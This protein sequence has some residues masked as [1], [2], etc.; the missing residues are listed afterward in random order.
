ML[1]HAN[2]LTT[3]LRPLRAFGTTIEDCE[4]WR[5]SGCCSSVVDHWLAAQAIGVR[6]FHF[7][8]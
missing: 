7:P 2:A 3:E 6:P 5:L 4:D 8:S 1:L